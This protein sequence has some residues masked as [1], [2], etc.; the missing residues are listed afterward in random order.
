MKT[1]E[2]ATIAAVGFGLYWVIKSLIPTPEQCY[3]EIQ[4]EPFIA[5][6]MDCNKA[7]SY[8]NSTI[9]AQLL[10]KDNSES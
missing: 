3:V 4:N 9:T 8:E 5:K 1:Y 10:D 7:K 6:W 2:L